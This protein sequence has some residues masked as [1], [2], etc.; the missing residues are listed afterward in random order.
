MSR[1]LIAAS[2]ATSGPTRGVRLRQHLRDIGRWLLHTLAVAVAVFALGTSA[3]AELV[4]INAAYVTAPSSLIPILFAEPGVAKHLGKSYS[5]DITFI[6]SS[7]QQI[8]AIAANRI[9]LGTTN[10][11]SFPS[12]IQNAGL[13]D[14]RIV[15]DELQDG[16]EGYFSAQFMVRKDSGIQTP[17]DLKGRILAINGLG[18]AAD[19]GIQV[20]LAKF[21]LRYP[22]DYT[23]IQVGFRN[24]NSVLLDKKADL[25]TNIMPFIFAPE[26]EAKARTLFTFRNALGVTE[27]SVWIMRKS[28]IDEHRA[29]VIDFLEDAV[30]AYR[31]YDDPKNR[32]KALEHLSKFMKQPVDRLGWAFA[33]SGPYRHYRDTNGTVAGEVLQHNIDTLKS[34]GFIKS[35][36]DVSKYLDMNLVKEAASR[37]R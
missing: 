2:H 30:R 1:A 6:P 11:A 16:R 35:G 18:G 10:F 27:L 25:I 5:F 34:M 33:T 7:S 28:F 22:G 13:T 32:D 21:G 20:E 26:I 8:T 9:Q 15:C 17:K 19:L 36:L 37:I 12:A 4:K 14:L 31:W 23:M 24:M 29:A 3:R